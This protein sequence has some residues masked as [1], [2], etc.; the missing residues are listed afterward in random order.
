MPAKGVADAR[1][2]KEKEPGSAILH[3][4]GIITVMRINSARTGLV[5]IYL[6]EYSPMRTTH[7]ETEWAEHVRRTWVDRED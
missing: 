2:Q 6:P 3:R 5:V 1:F 4:R 7:R